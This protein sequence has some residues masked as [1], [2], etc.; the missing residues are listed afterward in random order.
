[1]A[2]IHEGICSHHVASRA[3]AGKAFWQ[4]F[5]WPT[6][7]ADAQALV[8]SCE[9]CQVHSK[10]IHQPAQALHT[11]PMS[12][13]FT[14]RGLNVVGKFLMTLSKCAKLGLQVQSVVARV[15]F[16]H[17][18]KSGLISNSR[19]TVEKS[20][21]VLLPATCKIIPRSCVPNSTEWLSS[22]RCECK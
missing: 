9:A 16:S 4:G 5:Y 22:K 12:W 2:D 7:L 8:R 17:E 14:V 6:M 3:L 1:V 20:L 21:V 15:N 11:I 13:P 18:G 10:N 19:G